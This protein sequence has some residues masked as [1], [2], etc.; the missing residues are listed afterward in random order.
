MMRG[1]RLM[2]VAAALAVPLGCGDD[3]GPG[4]SL[5][6]SGMGTGGPVT[7]S[8]VEFSDD[9]SGPFPSPH[10]IITSGDPFTSPNV[11]NDA[12]GLALLGFGNRVRVRSAFT[13]DTSKPFT[14]SF[15]VSDYELEWNSK[16]RFR[17]RHSDGTAASLEFEMVGENEMELRIQGSE[18]ESSYVP[19]GNYRRVEFKMDANRVATWSTDGVVRMSRAGFPA[20]ACYVDLET[21]GS[22]VTKFVVDNVL[23][24]RP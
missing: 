11:G 8:A 4:A 2:T 3:D 23:L 6:L 17:I 9:S 18:T 16:F 5:G 24:T 22:S 1:L 20:D 15:D 19:T 21:T 14:F 7:H 10:W 12:P 13:F